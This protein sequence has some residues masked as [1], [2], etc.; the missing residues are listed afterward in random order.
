MTFLIAD[1]VVPSNEWRGYVLRKIMRRAMRHGR[2]LGLHEPFLHTLVDVLVAE[3]GDAYPELRASRDAVV[4]V[5]GAEEERFDAVL[6]GGLPR[7]EE[8]L[9]RAAAGARVLPGDE[10]FKLYDTFG[11]PRDFIEDLASNQGLRFDAEGFEREMEAQR[12]KARA[13]S[14]FKASDGFTRQRLGLKHRATGTDSFRWIQ[15]HIHRHPHRVPVSAQDHGQRPVLRRPGYLERGR[16]GLCRVGA[17]PFL[18]PSRWAG[19]G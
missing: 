2:K 8:A 4:Q 18:P 1:G 12:A 10:A 6:T 17:D 19:I 15:F 13:G 5:V 14:G 11:L 9:E 7:L 3:M 16:R